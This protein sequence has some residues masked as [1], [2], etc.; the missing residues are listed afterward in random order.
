MSQAICKSCLFHK[1]SHHIIPPCTS[2]WQ[3]VDISACCS[4]LHR[5][6]RA[7]QQGCGQRDNRFYMAC[8][9]EAAA[10][11]AKIALL[12]ALQDLADACEEGDTEKFTNSV[13]EF[14][15]MTRLDPWKTTL[16]LRVKKRIPEEDFT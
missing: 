8:T 2:Q 1:Q 9:A 16:L 11:A 15:S 7:A 12:G 4:A 6:S 3:R 10:A 5:A 14:D 13:A